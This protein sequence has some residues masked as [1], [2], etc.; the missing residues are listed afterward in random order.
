MPTLLLYCGTKFQIFLSFFVLGNLQAD[1]SRQGVTTS[2]KGCCNACDKPIVGQCVKQT[3]SSK[4]KTNFWDFFLRC[5]G[6]KVKTLLN[7]RHFTKKTVVSSPL[8]HQSSIFVWFFFI[9]NS[10]R[11]SD[12]RS[13]KDMASGAF[14]L[15]SL[16]PGIGHKKFLRAWWLVHFVK[17][18]RCLVI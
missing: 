14:H 12:Y 6:N 11:S 16:Q 5:D 10:I 1:M 18:V 3:Q 8:N 17:F 15:Q 13:W 9:L 2:Q 7:F 4:G